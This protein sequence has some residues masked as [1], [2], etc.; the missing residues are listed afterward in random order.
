M[1]VECPGCSDTTFGDPPT[2]GAN[3]PRAGAGRLHHFALPH[4][5]RAV[6][7]RDGRGSQGGRHAGFA[8]PSVGRFYLAEVLAD[9]AGRTKRSIIPS[10]LG[11]VTSTAG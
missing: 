2:G 11:A 8:K 1:W 4:P 10:V 6:H 5:R 7:C 3:A 9:V